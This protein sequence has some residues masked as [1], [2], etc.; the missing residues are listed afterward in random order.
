MTD[1]ILAAKRLDYESFMA[2]YDP[3]VTPSYVSPSTGQ[4][5]LFGA[6]AN[7][8]PAAR[9]AIATRLLDDGAAADVTTSSGTSLLHVLFSQ[10]RH[11]VPAEAGVLQ[12]LL[13]GGADINQ[14]DP[15][16]GAPLG[17]LVASFLPDEVL[18]P[19]YE[20]VFARPELDLDRPASKQRTVR[21]AIMD[22][23]D[24]FRPQL[25]RLVDG[26]ATGP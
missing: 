25:K 6:L 22:T 2:G 5:V 12:R 13:D 11:D 8:D 20:I 16:F 21:Q 18:A 24:T 3:A 15:R 9:V 1:P 23:A 26:S 10:R 7:R 17:I 4:T 19:F 14:V